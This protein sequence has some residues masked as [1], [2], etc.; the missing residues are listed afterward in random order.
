MLQCSC[1][2]VIKHC[3]SR[4][5]GCGFN[6]QG[7]HI[8]TKHLKPK[9]THCK[10]LWIKVSAICINVNVTKNPISSF[11]TLYSYVNFNFENIWVNTMKLA[12]TRPHSLLLLYPVSHGAL[13]PHT[14]SS[15]AV[16][17]KS[18]R[19]DATDNAPTDK[20]KQVTFGKKQSLSRKMLAFCKKFKL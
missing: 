3:I 5:K 14:P 13:K 12:K 20:T 18:Q 10:L 16:R 17:N 8:L 19:K 15:L 2:S 11:S 1:G 6:S 7:T 9:C 4:A